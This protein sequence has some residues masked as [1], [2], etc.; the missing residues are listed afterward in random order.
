M[1]N[2]G[3]TLVEVLAMLVVLALLMA[4]TIPNITGILSNQR[5]NVIRNDA[6]TMVETAKVKVAKNENIKKPTSGKCLVFSLD[7][8]ND[9]DNINNG[10]NGGTYDKYESFVIYT[11]SGSQY[12]YYVRLIEKNSNYNYGI[13]LEDINNITENKSSNIKKITSLIG[14]GESA[15]N[16]TVANNNSSIHSLCPGGIVDYYTN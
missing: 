16:K 7:Y 4:I 13:E 6:R 3:F 11:R 14:L 10:P 8:L 5:L 15:D 9:N 1:N 12:K 2:K